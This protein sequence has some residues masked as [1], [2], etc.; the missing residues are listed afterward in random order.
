[1]TRENGIPK[2]IQL[3]ELIVQEVRGGGFRAG[4][5]FHT[6]KELMARHKLSYA[7]VTRALQEMA[8]EGYF[9]RKKSLGTFVTERCLGIAV[10]AKVMA[11]PLYLNDISHLCSRVETPLAWFTFDQLQKGVI[12]AYNGP[13]KI[14]PAQ[15]ILSRENILAV[16]INPADME[17]AR[18]ARCKNVIINL[19]HD[20]RLEFNS[21]GRDVLMS[22]HELMAHLIAELGHQRVGFV[23]GNTVSYHSN[24]YAGY[25]IGLRTFRLPFR[26]DYVVRGLVGT[27]DDGREAMRRLLSLPEPPTAVFCDTDIKAFGAVK[28]AKEAG[29]KV[30]GDI[31][32]AGFGYIPE[33]DE[34]D[35]QLTTIKVPFYEMGKRAVELLLEQIASGGDVRTE[36]LRNSLL[37]RKSCGRAGK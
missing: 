29:L 11:E 15:E 16:I 13:V 8:A 19:R 1:M 3:K 31:S 27:E 10:D 23:G 26:E 37:I 28:A 24:L 6:E 22:V 35:P 4:D 5:K 7:T 21:V 18:A 12:N 34:F 20:V 2:Y 30:P 25:E 17:A 14:V 9:V 36:I 33:T 32:V